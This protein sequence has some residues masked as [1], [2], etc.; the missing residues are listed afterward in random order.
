MKIS[1]E[2]STDKKITA[3]AMNNSDSKQRYLLSN[4]YYFGLTDLQKTR[5]F[6]ISLS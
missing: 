6:M 2:E 1:F 4:Y 5:E 3:Q